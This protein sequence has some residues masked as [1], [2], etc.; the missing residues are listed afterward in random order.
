MTQPPHQ[1]VTKYLCWGLLCHCGERV[2]GWRVRANEPLQPQDVPRVLQVVCSKG[3]PR[4]LPFSEVL[5]LPLKCDRGRVA[6]VPEGSTTLRL[7]PALTYRLK[8][9]SAAF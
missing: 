9:D 4:I 8:R 3:H 2:T 7:K 5:S 6:R 1:S